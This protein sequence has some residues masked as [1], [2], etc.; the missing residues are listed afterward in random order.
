MGRASQRVQAEAR[1]VRENGDHPPL[2]GTL[3]GVLEWRDRSGVVRRWHVRQG[4]RLNNWMFCEP[5]QAVAK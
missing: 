5:G 3:I 2:P 4:R 1:M